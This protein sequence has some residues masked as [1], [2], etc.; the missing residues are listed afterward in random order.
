MFTT[1]L[2][3]KRTILLFFLSGFACVVFAQSSNEN[4]IPLDPKIK[5]G[6]LSNGFTYYIRKNIHPANQVVFYLVNKV[7]SIVETDNQQGLAHFMEHM[8]FNGTRHF[9]KNELVDY[10]QK[11]G[12]R[13]GADLNASTGFNETI[14]QLP[15][16]AD[17]EVIRNAI[18]IL[19][20]WARDASLAADEID[21]ERGVVIEEKRQRLGS[22]QRVQEKVSPVLLNHSRYVTR[23]PI[24]TD[25][26]L[27]N[28]DHDTLRKFY[29]DWYRPSLQALI[30]VGDIN[31]KEMEKM[32]I[33]KFSDL[34]NP[35]GAPNRTEYSI[36]L[37]G[38]NQYLAVTDEETPA[39]SISIYMKHAAGKMKTLDDFRKHML[40]SLLNDIISSRFNE[41][42]QQEHAPFYQIG[43]GINAVL[44]NVNSFTLTVQPKQGREEDAFKALWIEMERIKRYGFLPSE[45]E[46]AKINFLTRYED[47]NKTKD[48]THSRQ[49][50][51]EYVRNFLEGEASPGIS[52]EY[53][54]YKKNIA[55]VTVNDLAMLFN[56]VFKE[57]NRDII[58]SANEKDKSLIPAEDKI[59][60]WMNEATKENMTAYADKPAADELMPV[61]PVPGKIISEKKLYG[62]A[63]ITEIKLN[64][65]VR[66]LLKS[67]DFK[68]DEIQFAG[69]S[70][71]GTSQVGDSDFLSIS[72]ASAII[73]AS[74]VGNLSRQAIGKKMAG[75]KV[76][77]APVISTYSEGVNGTTDAKDIETALQLVYLYFTRPRKDIASFGQLKER[78]LASYEN[79]KNL[80]GT[81][82]GDT[83]SNVSSGYHIRNQKP[84]PGQINAL[85][86]DTII[87]L[88]KERFSDAGDFT[89]VFVGNFDVEKIK[90]LLEQYLGS[91][92]SAGRV[93]KLKDLKLDIAR[94]IHSCKIFGGKE[95]QARV[96][97]MLSGAYHPDALIN[98]ELNVLAG[99]LRLRL[100]ERLREEIGGIYSLD[101]NPVLRRIP[102][103]EYNFSINFICDPANV[104]LLIL[105]VFGEIGKIKSTG[106]LQDDIDKLKAA[107]KLQKARAIKENGYWLSLI[108]SSVLQ[109]T[110]EEIEDVYN[111]NLWKEITTE[112]LKEVAIQFLNGENYMRFVLL[113]ER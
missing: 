101:I 61:L 55:A 47:I 76:I 56:Q 12:V 86:L 78:M 110:E 102:T 65:G 48:I 17:K 21:K 79:T 107:S 3:I 20:D 27:K 57:T 40:Q 104:E 106:A 31:E 38:N 53:E 49:Y 4:A 88:Y 80:P 100:L 10:L 97:L 43:G 45:L 11:A 58:I 50:V 95:P 91:L 16:P 26:V 73:S 109:G 69:I 35:V 90:P 84:T 13:F 44:A 54:F 72:L 1:E 89:F 18:Q 96:L 32:I 92:P 33:S 14:Y 70:P 66:V 64:N 82:F 30:V 62:K 87:K 52:Y 112:S 68:K 83:V 60:Q 46:R 24:G 51:E 113:P 75:K 25:E 94:G 103:G 28:F 67:T 105:S 63:G 74:G 34:Q 37:T 85:Q 81:I 9:P 93:E 8:C 6:R 23:L 7:G 29:Y 22:F 19:R 108:S 59:L 98:F 41:I 2:N 39:T 42:S 36:A 71:G 111:E 5:T 15:V 99:V 77:V